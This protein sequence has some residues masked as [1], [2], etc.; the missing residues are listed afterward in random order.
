MC[1]PDKEIVSKTEC[2]W[3]NNSRW[4]SSAKHWLSLMGNMNPRYMT[5]NSSH[6]ER[7][8]SHL[9]FGPMIM[10]NAVCGKK[11]EYPMQD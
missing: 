5:G 1:R 4:G 3:G 6:Q 11:E 7:L 9:T 8:K 2:Q 10:M